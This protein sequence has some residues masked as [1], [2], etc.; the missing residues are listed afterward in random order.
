M[1]LLKKN[2]GDE[3]KSQKF[4]GDLKKVI[5]NQSY[6]SILYLTIKKGWTYFGEIKSEFNI[7]NNFHLQNLVDMSLLLKNKATIEEKE[8]I[9]KLNKRIPKDAL[10]SLFTYK[11][12][13]FGKSLLSKPKIYDILQFFSVEGI[14]EF[15]ILQNEK[16][17]LL[18]QKELQE[19][20]KKEIECMRNLQKLNLEYKYEEMFKNGR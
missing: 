13:E 7:Y 15:I 1:K 9:L 10:N 6:A 11:L 8:F 14:D 18:V 12:S 20:R 17:N 5:S 4:Q 16:Y 19:E 2:I 3:I